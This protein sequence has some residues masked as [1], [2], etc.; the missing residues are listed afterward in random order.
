M[1]E[2]VIQYKYYEK[3]TS[4]RMTLA[5]DTAMSENSKIQVLSNEVIRG[6]L[7]TSLNLSDSVRCDIVDNYAQKLVNSGYSVEDCN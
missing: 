4:K 7:N 1:S 6:L 3:P 5:K 2:G